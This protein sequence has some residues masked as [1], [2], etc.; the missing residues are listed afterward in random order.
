MLTSLLPDHWQHMPEL[1]EH[2]ELVHHIT[3]G[4]MPVYGW[5]VREYSL[6]RES[7]WMIAEGASF[8]MIVLAQL[9]TGNKEYVP[10]Q[11]RVSGRCKPGFSYRIF[12]EVEEPFFNDC[13]VQWLD[14]VPDPD[15]GL[16][17]GWRIGARHYHRLAAL[18]VCA[19]M[20]MSIT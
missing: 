14:E 5:A 7:L 9:A 2:D 6:V 1:K 15:V 3:R 12:G 19:S 10:P 16:S 4:V 8:T 20:D 18:P 17:T 11:H 13:P